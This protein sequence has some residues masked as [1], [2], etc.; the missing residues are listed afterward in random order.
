MAKRN[1]PLLYLAGWS[2]SRRFVAEDKCPSTCRFGVNCKFLPH[3]K[4]V[5]DFNMWEAYCYNVKQYTEKQVV[6]MGIYFRCLPASFTKENM[7]SSVAE[8]G[9]DCPLDIFFNKS[10]H[11]DGLQSGFIH[12]ETA[13]ATFRFIEEINQWRRTHD[14]FASTSAVI[15]E[16]HLEKYPVT[17]SDN[18]KILGPDELCYSA[19]VV[20][21]E[22]YVEEEYPFGTYASSDEEED[23]LVLEDNEEDELVLELNDPDHVDAVT[24]EDPIVLQDN[25]EHVL[26]STRIRAIAA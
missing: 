2:S 11:K 18:V 25:T 1:A 24:D 10:T 26:Q 3:C 22:V 14:D 12:F 13:A 21:K 20:A 9:L 19:S 15:N 6:F 23:P 17:P 5:H 4:Y 7:Y 16:K 8:C